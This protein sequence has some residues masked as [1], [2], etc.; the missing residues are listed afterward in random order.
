MMQPPN[1]RNPSGQA[2]VPGAFARRGLPKNDTEVARALQRKFAVYSLIWEA[3][4]PD[5]PFLEDC[6]HRTSV[7]YQPISGDD[8][9]RLHCLTLKMFQ[10][11][12]A[13]NV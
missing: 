10:L 12:E 2:G 9:T 13:L 11:R 5:L 4:L 3:V 1:E 8:R 7:L 6:I